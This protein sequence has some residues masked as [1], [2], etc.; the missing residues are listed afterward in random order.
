MEFLTLSPSLKNKLS[1]NEDRLLKDLAERSG[2]KLSIAGDEIE[3][4]GDG[5]SEWISIQVLQAFS[6]G[7]DEA[8]AFLL[9]DDE[10]F[11][12]V[13]DLKN[14]FRGNEKLMERYKARVIGTQGK[15]RLKLEELSEAF[16][17]ISDEQIAIIG[18]YEE[19]RNAKE[20]VMRLFEGS[21]HEV[22]YTFLEKRR[23]SMKKNEMGKG[24]Q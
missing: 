14:I 5:W 22:V 12:E 10:Y 20:A 4:E 1:K 2:A 17:S 6:L 23:H 16:I 11:M 7:F 3:I 18:K 8:K 19:L 15:A 24:I 13:L 21:T 9:F